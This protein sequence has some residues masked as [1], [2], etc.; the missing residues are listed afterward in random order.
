MLDDAL[1]YELLLAELNLNQGEPAAAYSLFLD[2]ARKT[3]DARLYQRAVEVALQSRA[4]DAALQAARAWK[5]AQPESRDAN[6]Y[7]LRILINLNRIRETLEPLKTELAA[8]SGEERQ[9]AIGSIP[10][11]YA[12]AA[13]KAAVAS[14]IERALATDL[15]DAATSG[16]AWSVV[17]HARL[18]AGNMAGAQEAAR[19]LLSREVSSQGTAY[20]ALELAARKLEAGEPLLLKQLQA[21]PDPDVRMAYARLLM[22]AQRYADSISQIQSLIQQKPDHEAAWLMLGALQLQ[23]QQLD[24]AETSLQRYLSLVQARKPAADEP[25]RA[26]TQ[27]YLYLSDIAVQRKD[28]VVAQRWLARIE[29]GQDITGVQ[30]RRATVLA[31]LGKLDEARKVVRSLPERDPDDARAKLLTEAQ[32]LRDVKQY[33]LAYEVLSQAK[34]DAE[35]QYEQAMLAEKLGD[36]AGMERLLRA[37]VAAKPDYYHAYNALGYSLAE[38]NVR[39][40]EARELIQKALEFAPSDPFITDS[41]GWVEFRLG[42]TREAAQILEGAFRQRPDAEIAAHLGE[43]LWSLGEKARA[44]TVWKEGLRLNPENETLNET[45]KRLRVKW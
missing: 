16:V 20:F 21:R 12:R 15:E 35:V 9:T 43:V 17:G 8:T 2:G 33:R 1:L 27:A 22:Q 28:Y 11:H 13:D 26:T 38:R 31:H 23:G 24:Q 37:A 39:L 45:L 5:N 6:R 18:S 42:N 10:R 3:D 7:V 4:G 29:N 25:E 44:L 41:M 19:Q 36:M 34:P 40:P 14:V 32:L 30:T